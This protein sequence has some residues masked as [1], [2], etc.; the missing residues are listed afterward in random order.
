[1]SKDK[2]SKAKRQSKAQKGCKGYGC[3]G[4]RVQGVTGQKAKK[5]Q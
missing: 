3:K 5:I 4:A 1:V 2:T